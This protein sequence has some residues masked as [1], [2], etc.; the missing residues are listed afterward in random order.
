MDLIC[1]VLAL[2]AQFLPTQIVELLLPF[3]QLLCG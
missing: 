2:L 3:Y 1:M